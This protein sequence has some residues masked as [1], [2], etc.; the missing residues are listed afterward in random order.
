MEQADE[1]SQLGLLYK[2]HIQ[3]SSVK[4]I[5]RIFNQLKNINQLATS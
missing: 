3:P 2:F 4:L 5:L 1:I